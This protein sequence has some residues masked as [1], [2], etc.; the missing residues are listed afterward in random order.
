MASIKDSIGIPEYVTSDHPITIDDLL[1]FH[2]SIGNTMARVFYT[3]IKRKSDTFM[4][5]SGIATAVSINLLTGAI[6]EFSEF[7]HCG[8]VWMRIAVLLVLALFN[9]SIV[10]FSILYSRINSDA[11][12]YVEENASTLDNVFQYKKEKHAQLYLGCY[13]YKN[14]LTVTYIFSWLFG[15]LSIISIIADSI[16]QFGG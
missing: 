13:K 8:D 16:I 1:R 12:D 9:V 14:L 11:N 15:A 6:P 4:F 2:N 10:L 7:T 5:V 3:V